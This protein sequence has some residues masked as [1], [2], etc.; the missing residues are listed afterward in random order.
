MPGPQATA[1][2]TVD[3]AIAIGVPV[4]ANAPVP[5]HTPA[6]QVGAAPPLVV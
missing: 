5:P 2:T 1:M 4:Y 6:L 3:A